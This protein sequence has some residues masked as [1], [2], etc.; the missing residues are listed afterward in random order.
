MGLARSPAAEKAT[1][2]QT[3]VLDTNSPFG[4]V[5]LL[6]KE[7][8]WAHR[9]GRALKAGGQA[10]SWG[11]LPPFGGVC[12]GIH[13]LASLQQVPLGRFPIAQ[14]QAQTRLYLLNQQC[15]SVHPPPPPEPPGE[16]LP[17]ALSSLCLQLKTLKASE[18]KRKPGAMTPVISTITVPSRTESA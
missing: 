1:E 15:Q 9:A 17:R 11:Q 16:G 13:T 5:S 3:T 6:Q 2:P 8:G 12:S 7:S 4:V 14:R 10:G 18:T